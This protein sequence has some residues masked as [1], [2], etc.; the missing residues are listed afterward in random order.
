MRAIM[1]A[2]SGL[3]C[4]ACTTTSYTEMDDRVVIHSGL[5]G[6]AEAALRLYNRFILDEKRVVIDGQVISADAFLAF[7]SPGACYTE[8]A[9]FSPHAAS[10]LGIVPARGA[11]QAFAA[12]L[13]DP[14]EDWFRNHHS[15]YDWI[16]FA[17]VRYH[18]LREIWPEGECGRGGAGRTRTARTA[19][20]ETGG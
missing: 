10:Y 20:H 11:T 5:G 1:I 15:Y 16:G 7:G 19:L 2:L 4:A 18:E 8:N 17:E 3:L 14:L 6:E 9:V 12:F 13:P